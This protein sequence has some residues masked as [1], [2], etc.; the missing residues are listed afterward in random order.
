VRQDRVRQRDAAQKLP[1]Q[2]DHVEL[3]LILR[4]AGRRGEHLDGVQ[5]AAVRACVEQ[6]QHPRITHGL[7]PIRGAI[8]VLEDLAGTGGNQRQQHE[9]QSTG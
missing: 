7:R 9:A 5:P 4:F 2:V 6:N 8:A 3:E 1:V